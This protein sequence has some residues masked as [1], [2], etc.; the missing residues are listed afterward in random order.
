MAMIC[1]II[2]LK[3]LSFNILQWFI[4]K[5]F[6]IPLKFLSNL[7]FNFWITKLSKTKREMHILF[8]EINAKQKLEKTEATLEKEILF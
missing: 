3:N 5:I 1:I 7:K 6:I 8:L 4:E 2:T